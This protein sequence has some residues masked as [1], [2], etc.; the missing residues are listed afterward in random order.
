VSKRMSE[1]V[2][3]LVCLLCACPVPSA[4][5]GISVVDKKRIYK[6]G[7]ILVVL[8]LRHPLQITRRHQTIDTLQD[9]LHHCN[10]AP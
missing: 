2:S 6:R 4:L 1:C 10:E 3:E 5:A 7:P 8:L 9:P